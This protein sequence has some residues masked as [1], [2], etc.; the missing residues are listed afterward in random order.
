MHST[1]LSRRSLIALAA[2]TVVSSLLAPAA[3][4]AGTECTWQVEHLPVRAGMDSGN[5][6]ITGVDGQGNVSGFHAPGRTDHTL[7]RWTS[8][9]VEVVPR[10]DGADKFVTIAGNASGVV[11]GV[12]DRPGA[13]SV[14]MT[15]TPGVGYR[16]LPTPAGYDHVAA[17]DINDRGDV[18]GRA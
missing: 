6:R 14:L 7:V 15:H 10:P 9:G 13:S 5:L 11:I 2:V 17:E 3:S 8:A 4:A 18:L 16:E 12:V 1:V